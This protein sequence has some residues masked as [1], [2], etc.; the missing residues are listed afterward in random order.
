M[1]NKKNVDSP[2]L[3]FVQFSLVKKNSGIFQGYST[4]KDEIRKTVTVPYHEI[5]SFTLQNGGG[6]ACDFCLISKM[7]RILLFGL[8]SQCLCTRFKPLIAVYGKYL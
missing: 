7:L 4:M 2:E 3:V 8:I 5:V 1:K 6:G